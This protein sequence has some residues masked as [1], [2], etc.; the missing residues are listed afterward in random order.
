M[1]QPEAEAGRTG[2][3]KSL[4]SDSC[5]YYKALSIL[6]PDLNAPKMCLK[7]GLEIT[8][9]IKEARAAWVWIGTRNMFF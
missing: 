1:G 5:Y 9:R 8:K 6:W 4:N 2:R 7:D 3:L